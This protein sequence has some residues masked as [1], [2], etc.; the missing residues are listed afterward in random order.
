MGVAAAPGSVS[1]DVDAA[2]PPPPGDAAW[3]S[4]PNTV[5]LRSAQRHA[6]DQNL[7]RHRERDF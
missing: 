7:Q 6:D 3:P 1:T 4:A 2:G 5:W